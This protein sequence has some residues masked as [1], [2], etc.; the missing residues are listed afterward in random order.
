MTKCFSPYTTVL[1]KP[2]ILAHCFTKWSNNIHFTLL[3]SVISYM[4]NEWHKLILNSF[5]PNI[6]KIKISRKKYK[7]CSVLTL[8]YVPVYDGTLAGLSS[9]HY[10]CYWYSTIYCLWNKNCY[11][12]HSPCVAVYYYALSPND[13]HRG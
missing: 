13:I 5:L 9:C 2:Y 8:I 10:H 7:M 1:K 4:M 6:R 11:F 3:R 12:L